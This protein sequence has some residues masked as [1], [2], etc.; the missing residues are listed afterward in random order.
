MQECIAL[1][2]PSLVALG[3]YNHLH[4]DKLSTKKLLFSFGIFTLFITLCTYLVVL[5]LLGSDGVYFEHKS[6]VLYLVVA[7]VFAFVLPFVVNLLEH[8]VAIE[9]KHNGKR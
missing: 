4:R 3:F 8:A 7:A 1:L 9:V 2:A 6:L 5:F